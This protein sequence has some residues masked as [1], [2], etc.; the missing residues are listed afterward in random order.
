MVYQNQKKNPELGVGKLDFAV[1]KKLYVVQALDKASLKAI[2]KSFVPV[3]KDLDNVNFGV[4]GGLSVKYM[5]ESSGRVIVG[6]ASNYTLWGSSSSGG[7]YMS[8]DA[9]L[10]NGFDQEL[11]LKYQQVLPVNN[12]YPNIRLETGYQVNKNKL[13]VLANA[14]KGAVVIAG[15]YGVLDIGTGKWDKMNR[16]SKKHLNNK[17]Y[18]MGPAI[19]WFGD[20]FIV[21]YYS[22][23]FFSTKY[24][25]SLQLNEK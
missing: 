4:P 14:S 15:V 2:K 20:N 5:N 9:L 24:D 17:A 22:R 21:P 18:S 19:L 23:K 3:N 8:E 10:I 16:L 12:S 6:V 7:T 11:Q 13:H 1:N 25:M